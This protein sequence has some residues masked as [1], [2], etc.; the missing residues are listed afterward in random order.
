MATQRFFNADYFNDDYFDDEYFAT[1][2]TSNNLGNVAATTALAGPGV[3]I[4]NYFD[5]G[6]FASGYFADGYFSAPGGGSG[7]TQFIGSFTPSTLF[8][9]TIDASTNTTSDFDGLVSQVL[10]FDLDVGF[11]VNWSFTELTNPSGT[12]AATTNVDAAFTGLFTENIIG[13]ISV[14]TGANTA[15]FDGTHTAPANRTGTI[16]A[17][18]GALNSSIEGVNVDPGGNAGIITTQVTK[19]ADFDGQYITSNTDGSIGVTLNPTTA[20]WVGSFIPAGAN[21][22]PLQTTLGQLGASFSGTNSDPNTWVEQPDESDIW[23]EEE[24]STVWTEQA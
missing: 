11:S 3:A 2:S 10:N 9:G 12:I 5:D 23:A 18:T 1:Q 13:S 22:G 24:V 14:S 15:D 8:S 7:A 16:P 19:V 4:G 20:T 17:A 6:Y 21:A